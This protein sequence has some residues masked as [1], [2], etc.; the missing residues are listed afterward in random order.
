SILMGA[1]PFFLD[2]LVNTLLKEKRPFIELF[3]IHTRKITLPKILGLRLRG[4]DM[5]VLSACE[6]GL[7]EVKSGEGVYGLRRAFI[8]AGAKSL[9]MSMWSVPD[10]ETKELMVEFYKNVLSGKMNR[11]QA[12]RQA[13]QKQMQVARERYGHTNPFYWGAFVF[14]GEP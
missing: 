12:L 9:V 1:S 7:G 13:S 11:C 2:V 10:R 3:R 5:V 8:Q 6:T 14:L 4:T